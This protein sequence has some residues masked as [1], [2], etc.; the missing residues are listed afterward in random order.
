MRNKS[1]F[2]YTPQQIEF[3]RIG[4]LSMTVHDLTKAFNDRF[5][6]KKTEVQIT[7]ALKNHG[8]RCGRKP[9][10]RLMPLRLYTEKQA[11]FIAKN[12]AG[13]SIAEMTAL[14]NDR[15][16]TDRT[17]QQIKTFVHNRGITSGRTG[18]F[19]KGN[20]P[21]NT[22]T[23]G[24]GLTGANRGSFKK[25]NVP[26]NRKPLGS[27]RICPKDGFI[28]IKVAEQDPNTGF[29]TCYKHKH[30]HIWEQAN[31][32]VPE[33]MVIAFKNG[34]KTNC[35]LENL[36]L[37][38]RAELLNLNQ[39]GYKDTPDE[40]KPSVLA[41]AKLQVRTWAKEKKANQTTQSNG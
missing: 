19:E 17:Q 1:R 34:D 10:D 33:G 36:M 11:R 24:Q 12:Y 32:P 31:G 38:S 30:V 20:K 27:E 22:G 14:F 3:L 5:G 18:R 13:Q 26:P 25:G 39:H 37:I 9:K 35:E 7:S 8:I 2:K 28:L 29:P 21:W 4:Y 41:L 6:L 40:L 15:F 16:G 23:K